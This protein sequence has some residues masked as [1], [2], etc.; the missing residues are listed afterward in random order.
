MTLEIIIGIVWGLFLL[1]GFIG[2]FIE[3]T[4]DIKITDR[5]DTFGPFI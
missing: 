3:S 1:V 4:K 2:L 5:N